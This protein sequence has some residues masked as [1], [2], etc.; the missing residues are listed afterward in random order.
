[1]KTKIYIAG[2]VT[3]EEKLKC[4]AKFDTAKKE[5]EAL[6]FEAINPLEVVGTWEIE[7]QPAMKLCIKALMDCDAIYHLPCVK[8]SKGAQIELQ[9]ARSLGIPTLYD[10]ESLKTID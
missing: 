3:G 2:K 10:I 7:W 9:I 6:G 5:V 8:F 1:M 4:I